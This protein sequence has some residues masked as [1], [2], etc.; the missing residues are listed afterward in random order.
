MMLIDI[1]AAGF[2]LRLVGSELTRRAGYDSTGK[3][4]DPDHMPERGSYAFIE[5]LTRVTGNRTPILYSENQ[6]AKSSVGAIGILLPLVG[7]AGSTE[8]VLGGVFYHP[9]TGRDVTFE[10]EPG[11]VTELVLADELARENLVRYGR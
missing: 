2:R 6:S 11:V 4:L 5:F 9:G 7:R 3:I 1:E 8:M 10:R